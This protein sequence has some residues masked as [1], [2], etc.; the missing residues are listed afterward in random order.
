MPECDYCEAGFGDEEAYLEHLR[1]AHEGELSRLEQR[2]VED[3]GPAEDDGLPMGPLILGF[4][5]ALSIGVVIYITMFMGGG[6]APVE[7]E[8][9]VAQ[10]PRGY[11]SAHEHGT[12]EMTV[13]GE[14][15]D[16]S[17]RQYQVQ[18]DRFHFE[19]GNGR[20]W[21]THAEGVTLEY[22]MATLG[23]DVTEN[24]ITYEG[25]T[26]RDSD[27]GVDVVIEVDGEPVDPKT[28]VLDGV[29]SA[30]GEGGEHVRIAVIDT[31]D[32]NSSG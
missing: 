26:Y 30:T 20:V 24:S 25:T 28:H 12:M 23:F 11:G 13:L 27:P 5:I 29:T 21:H 1:D 31:S 7:S 2:R 19:E 4:V 22:A 15:V 6:T 17:Q 16:F 3:L 8:Y 18:D 14:P 9:D 10:D 32:E